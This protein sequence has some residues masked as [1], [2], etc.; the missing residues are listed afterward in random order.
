MQTKNR[1]TYD[2]EFKREAVRLVIDGGR[3]CASV[4][5]ALGMPQGVLKDW[6]RAYRMDQENAFPGKGTRRKAHADEIGRLERELEA[7][8]RER[9]ILKKALGIFSTEPLRYTAL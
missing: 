9:D 6:V 7:T 1:R 3:S 8:R 2:A 4:E 5:R